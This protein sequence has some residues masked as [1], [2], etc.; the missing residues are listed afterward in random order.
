M[1]QRVF[2]ADLDLA[3]LAAAQATARAA[4][5][6]EAV[7][8]DA[9]DAADEAAR[10]DVAGRTALNGQVD[11]AALDGLSGGAGEGGSEP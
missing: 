2:S 6:S 11:R 10:R 7:A 4:E 8:A 3:R 5:D 1:L 9:A